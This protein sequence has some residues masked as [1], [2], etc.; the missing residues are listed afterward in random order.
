MHL[1]TK[2]E[3]ESQDRGFGKIEYIISVVYPRFVWLFSNK[4][5]YKAE[6]ACIE[7]VTGAWEPVFKLNPQ[8]WCE[9]PGLFSTVF[10][11]HGGWTQET[12]QESLANQHI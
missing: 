3:L 2:S 1:I 7:P 4:K 5:V 8:Y 11:A 6:A 12:L 10:T 9:K